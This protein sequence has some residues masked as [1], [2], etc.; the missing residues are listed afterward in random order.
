MVKI[1]FRM[2]NF[3]LKWYLTPKFSVKIAKNV[4]EYTILGKKRPNNNGFCFKY[5]KLQQNFG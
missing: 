2:T 3:T 1:D 4:I 5:N